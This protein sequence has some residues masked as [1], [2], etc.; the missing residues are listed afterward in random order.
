VALGEPAGG[1]RQRSPALPPDKTRRPRPLPPR[2]PPQLTRANAALAAAAADAQQAAALAQRR[3]DAERD[4]RAGAQE[5]LARARQ[6]LAAAAP[7]SG[8]RGPEEPQPPAM[9][10]PGFRWVLVREGDPDAAAAEQPRQLARGRGG[11]GGGGGAASDG[12]STPGTPLSRHSGAPGPGGGGGG[13]QGLDELLLLSPAGSCGA[14]PQTLSAAALEAFGSSGALAQ[15]GGVDGSGS[16][17]PSVVSGSGAAAQQQ[18]W[19][20]APAGGG[21]GGGLVHSKLAAP[22]VERLRA[23]LKQVR[24][25]PWAATAGLSTVSPP[26]CVA[27]CG[28]AG[29]RY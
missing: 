16:G 17:A 29:Q 12:G 6:E 26:D 9:A 20:G 24:G 19:R 23:A 27:G 18:G 13:G 3:L 22:G 2:R 7:A 5:E 14:P 8:R 11:A 10:G 21:G 25:A 15:G 1:C 4:A 28:A